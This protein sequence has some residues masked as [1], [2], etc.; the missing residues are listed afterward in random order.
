MI[1]ATQSHFTENVLHHLYGN[2]LTEA[3]LLRRGINLKA[4][5]IPFLSNAFNREA[6]LKRDG[7][8]RAAV[9]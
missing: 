9:L 2:A 8:R 7:S 1:S 3:Y 4:A 5:L 6:M